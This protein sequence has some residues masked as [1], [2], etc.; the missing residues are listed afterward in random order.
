[1]R[2]RAENKGAFVSIAKKGHES[3][4]AIFIISN[5]TQNQ[6]CLYIP[7]P[8]NNTE[9]EFERNMENAKEI[10]CQKKLK[11]EMEFDPDIWIVEIEHKITQQEIENIIENK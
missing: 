8:S 7:K 10:E 1:M 4:G 9:R 2:K 3:A 11:K 5:N 6:C